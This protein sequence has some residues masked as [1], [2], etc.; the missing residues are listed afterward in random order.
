MGSRRSSA[1][2]IRL[3]CEKCGFPFTVVAFISKGVDRD[4]WLR[5]SASTTHDC[6]AAAHHRVRSMGVERVGQQKQKGKK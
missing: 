3:T 6:D 4:A 2:P 5:E 1:K